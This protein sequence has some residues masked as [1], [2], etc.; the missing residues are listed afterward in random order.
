MPTNMEPQPQYR[1]VDKFDRTLGALT[2]LPDV[3]RTKP[4]T[5]QVLSPLIGEAQ[6]ITVQTYRQRE[7]GDTIF[8]VCAAA[9]GLVRLVIP[10]QAADA[11]ARQR[12]ALTT[13]NR[14]KAAKEQADAR[15]ARGEKPAFLKV[16]KEA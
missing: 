9:E 10:P 8:L 11:I 14:R 7:V 3:T 16:R 2:G 12:E 6:T 13:K 1:S 4:S 15:K 5:V